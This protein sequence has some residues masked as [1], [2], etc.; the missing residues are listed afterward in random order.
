MVE[1]NFQKRKKIYDQAQ[2]I[3]A[4]EGPMLYLWYGV[5]DMAYSGKLKAAS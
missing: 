5:E 1:G 4:T 3:L 2:E